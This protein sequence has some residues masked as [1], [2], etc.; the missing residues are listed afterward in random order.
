MPKDRSYLRR[1]PKLAQTRGNA[2]RGQIEIVTSR[3]LM[4]EIEAECASELK[5]S[6]LG[7]NGKQIGIL[8]EDETHIYVRDALRFPSGETGCRMRVIGK[9]QFDGVNGVVVLCSLNGRILLRRT[10]RHATRRWEL[11]FVRGRREIGT[12]AAFTVR[13]EVKEELGYRVRR[14]RRL[15]EVAPD[16]ALLSSYMWVYWAELV[17]GRRRDEPEG[18][19]ALG[20]IVEYA[21]DELDEAILSGEVRDAAT[22]CAVHF[23]RQAGLLPK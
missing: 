1:L 6:A 10:Y 20:D 14:L 12:T 21:A 23:A 17:P 7:T 22:I 18:T 15:G 8:L 13:K 3:N 4:R 9:T 5:G 16:T 2:K 19:E 11:E